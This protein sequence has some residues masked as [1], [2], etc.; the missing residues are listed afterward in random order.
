MGLAVKVETNNDRRLFKKPSGVQVN[1]LMPS[2]STIA[3]TQG[4]HKVYERFSMPFSTEHVLYNGK[5]QY[6]SR[7]SEE[8]LS[9]Q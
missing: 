3:A 6:L 1:L 9:G 4:D 8:I 5:S 2:K 7:D